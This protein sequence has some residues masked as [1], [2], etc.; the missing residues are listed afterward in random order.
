[1]KMLKFIRYEIA[2]PLAHLFNLSLNNGVFPASLK[3]SRTVPIFKSG[4]NTSCDNYRPISLLSSISKILEKIVANNLVSHLEN[5]NLIYENQYGF[6]R[7][8]STVHTITKLV[9]KIAMELNE[10]KFV[11]GVFLDLRK[12]FDVVQHEILLNKLNKLGIANTVLKWFTS[13]LENRQQFVDIGGCHS[14]NRLIDISVLQGSIL[15]PILFLCFIND[16]HLCTDLFTLL[17][18]DDTSGLDSDKD[19]NTL[20][21]RVNGEIQKI[22]NW[23]RANRMAVNVGKTKYIIFRPKG[24]KINVD[25]ENNG[26]VFN[27]N[28]IGKP[29]DPNKISKLGRIFNDHPDKKERSYKFLG[30]YLDEF[31]T[32]DTHCNHVRNKLAMSNFIINRAKNFLPSS[33]LKTLYYSLIHP[34]LLYGL[35]IY[36]CTSQK[37]FTSIFAM[38]KKTIRTISKSKHNASTLPLFNTL[39]ILPLNHLVTLTK[40]LLIHSIYHKYSP[41]ALHNTWTTIGQQNDI[42]D[43]DHDLRN[44]NDLYIPFARTEHVKRLT[45]FSL[46][47][48]WNTL[49]DDKF[50]PNKTTF[51]IALKNYLHRLVGEEA[52]SQ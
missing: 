26:I 10:K 14:S 42:N 41:T 23:F 44:A 16:L 4:D 51:K 13:Y 49:P 19:L 32:F 50:T 47:A 1:M 38:Q 27:S 15:G 30:I 34:H 40:G 52:E 31:L 45:Y 8:K 43:H 22:A 48:T 6:L 28:E 33:T 18:A 21:N 39:K 36:S 46:P 3:V 2:K 37:N 7:G 35:P 20:I 24:T 11:I 12:A 17:F 9:N 29:N 5:N 25:L